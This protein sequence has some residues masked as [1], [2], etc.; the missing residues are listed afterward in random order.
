MWK[1]IK[2]FFENAWKWVEALWEKHDEALKDIVS[3]VLPMVI[4]ITFRNDLSG[5]EKKNTIID[6]IVDNAEG[7]ADNISR[8]ILN[9]AVEIA[10]N[11]YNI[12]IGKLTIENIDAAREAALKTAR[13][14]A[15]HTLDIT[16]TEAEDADINTPDPTIQD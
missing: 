10:V 9:E 15:N 8:S 4:D 7:L 6:T 12:Q 2:E 11:R 1:K 3:A 16:G 13:D 5:E 14:F